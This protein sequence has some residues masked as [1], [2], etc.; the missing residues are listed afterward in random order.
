[1]SAL[2]QIVTYTITITNNSHG[3]AYD[4]V[5]SDVLPVGLRY[6]S[7]SLSGSAPPT[8]TLTSQPAANATG[9]LLWGVNALWGTDWNGSLPGVARLTVRAQVTDTIG[10]GLILTNTAYLPYYDSQPGPGPQQGLTPT[11]REY[12]DGEDSVPLRTVEPSLTKQ[13]NLITATVSSQIVYTLRLPQPPISATLF[14]VVFTDDVPSAIQITAVSANATFVGNQVTA[15]FSSIPALTQQT[16]I[17]T[18][19]VRGTATD[20]LVLVDQGRFIYDDA[21]TGGTTHP[22][23]WSNPV[24]TTIEIPALVMTKTVSSSIVQPGDLITYTV[25]VT[26]VGSGDAYNVAITDVLPGPAFLYKPGSSRLTWPGPGS[27]STADP[28]GAGTV[29]SPYRLGPRRDLAGRRAARAI[30]RLDFP[31]DGDDGDQR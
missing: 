4:L 8:I 19:T 7:S 14:T 17:I 29:A 12:G 27:P 31:G 5:I 23:V 11:Q 18:G 24:T 30:A 1:M 6:L 9:T 13:V 10:A 26:N 16:I 2:G 28:T 15:S 20:G 22:P 25:A 21:A 3:P